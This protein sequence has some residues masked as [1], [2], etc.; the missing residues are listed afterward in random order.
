MQIYTNTPVLQGFEESYVVLG[1]IKLNWDECSTY[2]ND[3]FYNCDF[4]EK[5]PM[6]NEFNL[7][8]SQ[9]YNCRDIYIDSINGP[10]GKRFYSCVFLNKDNDIQYNMFTMESPCIILL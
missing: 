2:D 10:E 9:I 3:I 8:K 1:R 6:M 4:F 5:P 7:N